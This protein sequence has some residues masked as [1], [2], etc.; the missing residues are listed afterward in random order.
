VYV[1]PL[2]VLDDQIE[3]HYSRIRDADLL[4]PIII[5]REPDELYYVCDGVH[6]LS[7]VYM[8]GDTTIK[9]VQITNDELNKFKIK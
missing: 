7:K 6:R 3:P 1:T 2:E 5:H 9:T 4:Y 8:D